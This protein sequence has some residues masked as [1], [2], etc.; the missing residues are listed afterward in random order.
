MT[1]DLSVWL[2][3]L[4]RLKEVRGVW[5]ELAQLIEDEYVAYEGDQPSETFQADGRDIGQEAVEAVL[6][7]IKSRLEELEDEISDVERLKVQE[8]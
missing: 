8:D 7:D 1:T 6:A 3:K 5:A 4:N 2:E